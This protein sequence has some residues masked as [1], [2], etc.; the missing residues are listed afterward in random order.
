MTTMLP[1]YSNDHLATLSERQLLELMIDDE[2]R[3]PFNVI[4]ECARRAASMEQALND[5]FDRRD[6]LDES[7]EREWWL[8]I[9]CIMIFGLIPS[10]HAGVT[11]VKFMRRMQGKRLPKAA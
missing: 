4:T 6:M 10:E 3:V 2:D 11:L 5:W 7:G 8:L 9:H 1:T